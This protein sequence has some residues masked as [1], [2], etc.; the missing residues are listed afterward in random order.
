[1]ILYGLFKICNKHTSESNYFFD[2]SLKT[3]NDLWGIKN[4]EEV[5][6]ES[7]KN[8][9]SQ[10]DIIRV[11]SNNFFNNLQKNFLINQVQILIS[12][13]NTSD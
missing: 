8:G 12:Y 2:N 11:P 9:F 1:M 13:A 4:L 5:C 6:V 10:E 3:Q 7:K